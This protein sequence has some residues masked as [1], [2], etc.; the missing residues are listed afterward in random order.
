MGRGTFRKAGLLQGWL[1]T[2]H[3]LLCKR[4]IS[5]RIAV[6]REGKQKSS[7]EVFSHEA[8]LS[9]NLFLASIAFKDVPVFCFRIS[10]YNPISKMGS[11]G[12]CVLACEKLLLKLHEH[13]LIWLSHF[14]FPVNRTLISYLVL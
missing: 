7:F 5:L 6:T 4:N 11:V 2:L 8:P 13:V 3:F 14:P 10:L 9:Q 1:A 12:K